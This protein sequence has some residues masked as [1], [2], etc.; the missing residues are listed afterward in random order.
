V[1]SFLTTVLPFLVAGALLFASAAVA[2]KPRVKKTIKLDAG[3]ALVLSV[4][5]D[6]SQCKQWVCL[7]ELQAIGAKE[8][9]HR[10]K[11]KHHGGWIAYAPEEKDEDQGDD[12][13]SADDE[14]DWAGDDDDSA[15]WRDTP[16]LNRSERINNHYEKSMGKYKVEAGRGE[17]ADGEGGRVLTI[18]STLLP[19]GTFYLMSSG[20]FGL[21]YDGVK[22]GSGSQSGVI[23]VKR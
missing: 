23:R 8:P 2:G 1:K 18:D 11:L 4:D 3:Q 7:V 20:Y 21:S 5:G 15:D 19:A 16:V 12:D 10:I 9:A 14:D 6:L 13:D 17:V 22:L